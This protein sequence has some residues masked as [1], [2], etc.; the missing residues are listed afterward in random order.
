MQKSAANTKKTNFEAYVDGRLSRDGY[1]AFNVPRSS[2]IASGLMAGLRPLWIGMG[3]LEAEYWDTH[4]DNITV[5]SPVYVCGLA[6]SGT[7]ILLNKLH[8]TGQ[9]ASHLYT[10][11]PFIDIPLIWQ[12]WLKMSGAKS[13][14]AAERTH[15]DRIEV[16]PESPEALEEMI[17]SAYFKQ[18]HDPQHSNVL[19]ASTQNEKFAAYYRTHLAKILYL[20]GK[21]RYLAKGNYN[22]TRIPYINTLFPDA[23]F[24]IAVRPPEDHI[25]SLMK[26]HYLLSKVQQKHK[27]GLRYMQRIGHYEFGLDRRPINTGNQAA[28]DEII[29]CWENGEELKGW[30]LYYRDLHQWLHKMLQQNSAAKKSSIIVPYPALC[31]DSEITMKNVAAFLGMD[32]TADM[33][34]GLSAPTYYDSGFTAD[35]KALIN[36]IALPSYQELT[37]SL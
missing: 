11:Y 16:S 2:D 3:K 20:R 24:I 18:A 33:A 25:A 13:S 30:A 31:A 34:A 4:L 35:E 6:R 27:S 28:T 19:D 15:L 22:L 21:D 12:N 1:D 7:T 32:F 29:Q 5:Q 17:W 23:R 8:G 36:E 10:D 9:F 26:Q 37:G 14:A